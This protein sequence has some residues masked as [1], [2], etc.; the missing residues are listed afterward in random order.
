MAHDSD[1]IT[2]TY[3]GFTVVYDGRGIN[4]CHDTVNALHRQAEGLAPRFADDT[5]DSGCTNYQDLK[6]AGPRQLKAYALI[7]QAHAWNEIAGILEE[8]RDARNAPRTDDRGVRYVE[9]GVAAPRSFAAPT[10]CGTCGRTWDDALVTGVT[11][12]PSARCPFEAQHEDDE[13][14]ADPDCT[15]PG[16]DFDTFCPIHGKVAPAT[17]DSPSAQVLR[18]VTEYAPVAWSPE[19]GW[20]ETESYRCPECDTYSG[21]FTESEDGE[22]VH[23]TCGRSGSP[24]SFHRGT[25]EYAAVYDHQEGDIDFSDPDPTNAIR[26]DWARQ[27][28][29]TFQVAT[30]TDDTEAEANLIDLITDLLHLAQEQ[31]LD[32]QVIANRATAHYTTE[33]QEARP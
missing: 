7:A 30:G 6:G 20:V 27:A 31:G 18:S 22:I 1:P 3:E 19:S 26:A 16:D 9:A 23:S 21:S 2:A 24:A 11:P 17:Y 25:A 29:D 15:C 33:A 32:A 8:A 14:F 4:A 12:A 5:A 28:L 13:S 10:T